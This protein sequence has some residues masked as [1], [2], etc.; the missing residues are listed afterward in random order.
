MLTNIRRDY[1]EWLFDLACGDLYADQISYRKL[2][3]HLHEVEF[4]YVHPRDYNRAD[5]GTKLRRRYVLS[6]IPEG[7]YEQ[8]IDELTGPC[9]VLEMMLAL[10]I[11]CEEDYMGDPGIGDRTRQW[12]WSMIR[13]LGLGSMM[14]HAY[15]SAYI[16]EVLDRFMKREY[17]ANG[18]GGLFTIKNCKYDLRDFEI[19]FQ[20][21][22]YLDTIV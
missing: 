2:L 18:R 5:D 15:D 9:S 13:S 6:I 19:W 17:E 7:F 14:D 4:I 16:N 1:F 3:I 12:F 11:R 22:W 21:G 8:A 20:M 10:A